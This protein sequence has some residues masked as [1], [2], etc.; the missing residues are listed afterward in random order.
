[1]K[2]II[3]LAVLLVAVCAL[4][5]IFLSSYQ[6][7]RPEQEQK[8]RLSS[9][10]TCSIELPDEISFAGETVSLDRYDLR[11]RYDREINSFTYFHSTTL[12]LIKRANRYFP[13]IEPILKK[14]GIPDDFKYLAVIE[15]SLNPRAYSPAKASGLWQFMTETG[16]RYGLEVSS[17]V[18]ERY[19]V[20]K[21]T[22]AAC[23]YLKAAYSRYKNWTNAALSYN[24]G[25]GR[26]NDELEKQQSENGLDLWLVEE[27]SRYYFRMVAA[28]DIFE[29]PFRY[30]FL[31]REH[32]LYKP[33]EFKKVEVNNNIDDLAAFA[34]EQG[35]TYAQLKEFNSWLR[36]RKLTLTSSA[37]KGTS[38][39]PKSYTILIPTQESLYYKKGEKIKVHNPNWIVEE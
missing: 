10:I 29:S 9:A 35:I 28:K 5:V 34:K 17:E 16:K 22:E 3:V 6:N 36:D 25:M 37:K 4:G 11:E 31:L 27:T 15:S 14:N 24:A 30:G 18:D 39:A 7:N 38:P 21:S 20:E 2:K 12:L 23:K 32:Q 13:I 33:M 26:I 8:E 19:S 1:M